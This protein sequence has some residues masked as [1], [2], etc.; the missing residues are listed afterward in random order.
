[1]RIKS[2]VTRVALASIVAAVSFLLSASVTSSVLAQGGKPGQPNISAAEQNF[3]KA[4][5]TAPNP[6]A[7]LKV[8]ADLIKKYPKSS[9]R[10]SVARDIADQIDVVAD[11]SQKISLAQEY[12][13]IFKDPTEQPLIVAILIDGYGSAKRPDEAFSTGSEFVAQNPDA[14]LA[15]VALMSVGTDQAK[16]GNAKFVEPSLQ[17]GARAI[18]LI[19]ANKKPADMDDAAWTQYKTA[20]LPGLYRSLAILNLVKGDRAQSK[21]RITKA[22]E[23]APTDPYNYLI[24]ATILN[25]EYQDAGKRYQ[26]LPDGKAKNDELQ[27][28]LAA[29]DSVIDA[30]AHLIALSEGLAPLQ[31]ARQQVMQDLEAYYKFRHSNSAAGMQQLI[32]KYKVAAKP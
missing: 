15:L 26:N 29:L 13:G 21:V 27:R 25:E 10:A 14:V 28:V 3:L 17:Y 5:K 7:K 4:I 30:Y 6:A 32:D 31:Q 24:L 2:F 11:A 19:E 18:E 20:V 1:M 22:V 23:I 12:R 16:V 9:A 8:A